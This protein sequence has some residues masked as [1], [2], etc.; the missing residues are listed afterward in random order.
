[1]TGVG[2]GILITRPPP[3][4][5]ENVTDGD[6]GSIA[7]SI[8]S[9]DDKIFANKQLLNTGH[10]P[11]A[12]RIVG[13][14]DEIEQLA[15]RL[16]G[17]VNGYAPDNVLIYGKTGTGKSLVTRHVTGRVQALAED[18]IT[19][20]VTYVDCAEDTTE[21]QVA[22]SI[23]IDLNDEDV[24]D[25]S[26]PPTG[27]GASKYYKY[28]WEIL[29]ELY[30]V[31]IVI[32]DEVDLLKD[33]DLLMKL[34]RAEEADKVD[35]SL[36][37]IA[38]SNKLGYPDRLNERTKSSLQ[39]HDLFFSPYDADQLREILE[40][41]RDAFKDDVLNGN[42]IPLCAAFAAREHG[43]ARKA[44]DTLRHAGEHAYDRDDELVTE[45]HVHA[46][47]EIAERERFR[48]LI[49]NATLQEKLVLLS[50]SE[51]AL[52]NDEEVFKTSRVYD[53]Y[54]TI[55]TCIDIETLSIRRIRDILEEQAFLGT[56]EIEKVGGGKGRG[57]YRTNQLLEDPEIVNEVIVA[58]DRV[59]DWRDFTE[60]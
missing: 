15:K 46:A 36:G 37:L 23:S 39:H 11:E 40:N 25:L 2:N 50:L 17:S 32:L 35:C 59:S 58:D 13:R 26:I 45:D 56:V 28:L 9:G 54:E 44:I 18:D 21:T 49:E 16:R 12:E 3:R 10:V 30:D 52:R 20:G 5:S 4:P 14:D 31:C 27:Y 42:V 24:T 19:I 47:Q 29:D 7:D 8:L 51:L 53:C 57:V 48:E 6:S 60:Q 33:D 1:M 22:S 55:C 34:S 38:I 43:D 41:R